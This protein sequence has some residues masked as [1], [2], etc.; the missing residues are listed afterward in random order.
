MILV[1]I[2]KAKLS[3]VLMCVFSEPA[4]F[5]TTLPHPIAMNAAVPSISANPM[6]TKRRTLTKFKLLKPSSFNKDEYPE[7]KGEK[8]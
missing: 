2:P 8:S 5:E 1:E 4:M 7:T 3:T 6:P